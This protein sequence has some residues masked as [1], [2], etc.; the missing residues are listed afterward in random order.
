MNSINKIQ[1]DILGKRKAIDELRIPMNGL[2]SRTETLDE[3]MN[4]PED[5]A[6]R[7][8]KEIM[9]RMTR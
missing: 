7:Y 5:Q 4:D 8:Q 2:N 6:L 3:L 1:P 9:K